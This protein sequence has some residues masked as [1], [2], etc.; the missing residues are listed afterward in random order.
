VSA[1]GDDSPLRISVVI[2]VWRDAEQLASLLPKLSQTC[3]VAETI[4]VNASRDSTPERI[5]RECGAT[6]L[7]SSPPNRGAQLN[8]GALAATGEVLL[9]QHA[10]TELTEAHLAAIQTA[11]RNQEVIGGA[12]YRKFD[13]RHPR[14]I[15]LE[16]VARFLSR[17]RG[18][19]YGDQSVFVRREVFQQLGGFAKIPL[20]EDVEFSERLRAAGRIALLDP[21]VRSSARH[22]ERKG[23]WR[24]TARNAAFIVLYRF[25]VSP[26][27]L[28][29]WYYPA[30]EVSKRAATPA[31]AAVGAKR[32]AQ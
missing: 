15:W 10:D 1:R 5:A 31:T 20:M 12:F 18:T 6:F 28:H 19:L 30:H 27:R 11:L 17:N 7:K 9:F 2:P 21:P 26:F 22:H 4:V 13:G 8:A 25:G 24:T 14:L 16:P 32:I 23:A 3:R 29:R